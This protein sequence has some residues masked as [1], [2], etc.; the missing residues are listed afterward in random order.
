[1]IE[2]IKTII[3]YLT[4]AQLCDMVLDKMDY[5]D[6]K[7]L[8]SCIGNKLWYLEENKAKEISKALESLYTT[9]AQYDLE[10]KGT[11]AIRI[12]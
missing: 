3:E 8:Y 5:H 4:T 7:R 12:D 11:S 1:M 9:A 2:P 10:I 6:L